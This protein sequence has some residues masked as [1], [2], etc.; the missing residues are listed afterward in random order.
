MGIILTE[1][2]CPAS[3]EIGTSWYNGV[4]YAAKT[5]IVEYFTIV[6]L[7]ACKS[8]GL[9]WGDTGFG[10]AVVCTTGNWGDQNQTEAITCST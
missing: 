7:A 3:P 8:L 9:S 5:V 4:T 10:V 6:A 2:F 1:L